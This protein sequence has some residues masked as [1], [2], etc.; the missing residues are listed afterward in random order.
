[1]YIY[2]FLYVVEV[3]GRQADAA[4]AALAG[5]SQARRYEPIFFWLLRDFSRY[6]LKIGYAIFM[7]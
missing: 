5:C 3:D 2:M 7:N 6:K 1:M 4:A